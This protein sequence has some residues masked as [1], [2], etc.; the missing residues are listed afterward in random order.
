MIRFAPLTLTGIATIM[1]LLAACTSPTPP[2]SIVAQPTSVPTV[3]APAAPPATATNV[4]FATP[5]PIAPTRTATVVPSA[6][7]Q[8][9]TSTLVP[10]V[11]AQATATKAVAT[12]AA[13]SSSSSSASSAGQSDKVDMNKILPPGKGQSLLLNNCTSC[14]SFVCAVT[15]QRTADY[16]QTIK[17]G[18]TERVSGLAAADYDLL[19]S[20]L[21]ENFNDKKPVPELPPALKDLGCSAQ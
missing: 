3:A 21:A 4:P 16:W 2:L 7:T 10:T 11:S 1:F 19:F 13:V 6:T 17:L 8:L 20:Y 14:H 5:T 18:H 15:G 12:T 9:A